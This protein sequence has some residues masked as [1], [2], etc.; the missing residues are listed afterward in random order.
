MLSKRGR[1]ARSGVKNHAMVGEFMSISSNYEH[2]KRTHCPS[3][4]KAGAMGEGWFVIEKGRRWGG[5]IYNK[6][7]YNVMKRGPG[8]G[9]ITKRKLSVESGLTI[10][11]IP[12]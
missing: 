5:K 11:I 1:D 2:P 10:I 6:N 3:I 8:G 4:S 7:R 9:L 12:Q